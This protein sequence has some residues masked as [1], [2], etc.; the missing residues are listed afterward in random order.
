MVVAHDDVWTVKALISFAGGVD[1]AA[2][3]GTTVAEILVVGATAGVA[4]APP[5]ILF[6]QSLCF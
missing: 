4:D 3:V 2:V 5:E 1:V 6:C